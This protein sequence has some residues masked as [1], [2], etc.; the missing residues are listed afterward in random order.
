VG[1]ILGAANTEDVVNSFNRLRQFLPENMDQIKDP[2]SKK[3]VERM[4]S[5]PLNPKAQASDAIR[6]IQIITRSMTPLTEAKS[7]T[8][9]SATPANTPTANEANVDDQRTGTQ[10]KPFDIFQWLSEQNWWKAL[11]EWFHKTFGT[12]K[13][14]HMPSLAQLAISG[15]TKPYTKECLHD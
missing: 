3:A 7:P 9:P 12:Q 2:D 15:Y 6:R 5:T 1:N 13:R 14:A 10:E 4:L 11:T 8:K